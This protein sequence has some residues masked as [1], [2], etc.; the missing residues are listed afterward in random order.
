MKYIDLDFETGNKTTDVGAI[1]AYAYAEHPDTVVLL[2]CYTLHPNGEP[3]EWRP[4]WP[5]PQPLLDAIAEGQPIAAHNRM[6]EVCIWNL[7]CVR[8]YGWEPIPV[9]YG[10]CTAAMAAFMALP[11]ALDAVAKV[12]GYQE[13][14]DSDGSKLMRAMAKHV[15]KP[16]E[17]GFSIKELG[18]KFKKGEVVVNPLTLDRL[19]KYCAQ[20]NRAENAILHDP[21]I[22]PLTPFESKVWALDQRISWRGAHI[23]MASVNGCIAI[24]ERAM[25]TSRARMLR[26][27]NGVLDKVSPKKILQVAES[28]GYPMT[29]TA[30]D[31]KVAA[32]NDPNCPPVFKAI[33]KEALQL[34]KTSCSKYFRMRESVCSDGRVHG[35][36]VYSGAARTHR[37]S[38]KLV[39]VQNL[40][41]SDLLPHQVDNILEFARC[42]NLEAIEVMYGDAIDMM[43]QCIRGCIVAAPGKELMDADFNAVEARGLAWLAGE[44]WRLDFFRQDSYMGEKPDIYKKSYA[45]TF[46]VPYAD[47]TDKLRKIGKVCELALGYGGGDGAMLNFGADKLGMDEDERKRVKWAWRKANPNIAEFWDKLE[48]AAIQVLTDRNSRVVVND[49]LEFFCNGPYMHIRL[50]SGNLLSYYGAEA[51]WE[52][53]DWGRQGY[54]IY[55]WGRKSDEGND[56]GAMWTRLD[57]YGG[58]LSNNVTQGHCRD[59]MA[60]SQLNADAAG[61][62]IIFHV[63]DELICEQ[64]KGRGR[65]TEFEELISEMPSWSHDFPIRSA[66][67]IGHRFRKD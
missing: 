19:G 48:N 3:V 57:T 6:F 56:E 17:R 66:G 54:K 40:K 64:D 10:I 22:Y 21:A 62:D 32:I 33:L 29:S 46:N 38:G 26:L 11:R 55:Y 44:Q 8:L 60:N 45:E 9:D 23:D 37:W 65:L 24:V 49:K 12:R 18:L 63:H 13:Q 58:K 14:K 52:T 20:D 28:F 7:L 41:A 50:P 59:L 51:V 53:N 47:I 42:G 31:F 67:W 27:S 39:Q 16:L 1:G 2:F 61:H 34:S 25:T 36:L 35:L 4:G 5:T 30:K 15:D 43:S